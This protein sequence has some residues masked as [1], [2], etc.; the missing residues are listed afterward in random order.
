MK[1]LACAE[2]GVAWKMP[3][4]WVLNKVPG[5]KFSHLGTAAPRQHCLFNRGSLVSE[6][7]EEMFHNLGCHVKNNYY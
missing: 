4:T 2:S 1:M 7:Q 6:M 5:F 3:R